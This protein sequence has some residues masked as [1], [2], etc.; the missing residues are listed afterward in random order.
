[1]RVAL[2]AVRRR[3]PEKLVMAV[4]VAPR[5]TLASFEGQADQIVCLETPEPFGAVGYFY[6]DF[7]P[8][9]DAEVI[10]IMNKHAPIGARPS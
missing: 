6:S 9:E 4:P 8:T 7:S 1:M 5:S 10:S 3:H 2:E